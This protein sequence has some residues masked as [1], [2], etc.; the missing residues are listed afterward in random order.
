[1]GLIDA[2]FVD[3]GREGADDVGFVVGIKGEVGIFPVAKDAKAL[4]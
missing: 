1:M 4:E 3:Q 2:A